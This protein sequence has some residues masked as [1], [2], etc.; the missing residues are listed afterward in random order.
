MP[1]VEIIF[2]SLFGLVFGGIGL[3]AVVV[4]AWGI[5]KM[6]RKGETPWSNHRHV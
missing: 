2:L 5:Y 3:V 6:E 1:L 4:G